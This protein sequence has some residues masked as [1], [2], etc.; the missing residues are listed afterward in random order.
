MGIWYEECLTL[1][2]NTTKRLFLIRLKLRG[3]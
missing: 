2:G 3:P 1:Q